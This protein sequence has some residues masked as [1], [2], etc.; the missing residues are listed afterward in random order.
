MLNIRVF[1]RERFLRLALFLTAFAAVVDFAACGGNGGSSTSQTSRL[2]NRAFISNSYSG[3]IQIVDTQKDITATSGDVLNSFGQL[4]PG[5]PV[6]IP[7]SSTLSFEVESPDHSVTMAYNPSSILMAFVSNSAEQTAGTLTMGSG[8]TSA[9]F[10]PD[11]NKVYAAEPNLTVTGAS[12]SG[13]IQ[14]LNRPTSAITATYAVP[15]V[16]Y[17][18]LSPSGQFLLAF[19]DNSDSVFVID[20]NAS[21]VTPVEVPGFARPINAV[22]SSDNNTAY[23]LNCG[24]ECGSTGPASVTKFDIPSQTMTATVEVGGASVGL[25]NGTTLYVAGSPVPPGTSSTY[26]AVNISDMTRITHDSVAIGDG[27]HTT[28]ALAPNNKLYIG[29]NTC[30]NTVTGCLSVVDVSSNTADPALP[31][32]GAVTSLLSVKSRNVIYAVEGGVLHIYNTANNSLQ[33]TQLNFTGALY[34]IVQVDP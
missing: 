17:L 13:G 29:A 7:V 28:M 34:S 11:S 31:P 27:F 33:P 14:V 4:V 18:A 2:S 32:R 8:V 25:L 22:F 12:R 15:S 1:S 20:L 5:A 19:A 6:T 3:G 21:T 10:S 16:R 26:D 30:S 23:V 9:L 24:P